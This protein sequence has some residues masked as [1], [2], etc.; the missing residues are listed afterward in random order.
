MNLTQ[1][2]AILQHL[3]IMIFTLL[4]WINMIYYETTRYILILLYTMQY[5]NES[6]SSCWH[7]F[8][9]GSSVM[10]IMCSAMERH[11]EIARKPKG[12]FDQARHRNSF[13]VGWDGW[14]QQIAG[15]FPHSL[16]TLWF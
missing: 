2:S 12:R 10:E 9:I 11:L 15:G 14:D 4:T 13:T 6:Q 8:N 5:V 1:S 16:L 3:A 7:A